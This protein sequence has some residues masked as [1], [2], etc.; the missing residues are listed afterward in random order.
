MN[1]LLVQGDVGIGTTAPA[2][3]LDVAGQVNATSYCISGANC[4]TAWPAGSSGTDLYL[5]FPACYINSG[6]NLA[7]CHGTE[8]FS[9]AMPDTNYTITCTVKTSTGAADAMDIT[10]VSTSSFSYEVVQVMSNGGGNETPSAY[11]HLHHA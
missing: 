2:H 1:G 5:N 8:T 10:S 3:T 7:D 9:P 4:I 11:C 6:S